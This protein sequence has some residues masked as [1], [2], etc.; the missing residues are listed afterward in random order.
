MN[1]ASQQF[2]ITVE[3]RQIEEAISCIFHTLLLHRSMGKFQYKEEGSFHISTLGT[4]DVDCDFINL[5]YVRLSSEELA[6]MLQREI[7][8]FLDLMRTNDVA[9][10]GEISIEFY[11][12]RRRNWLF[13]EESIPWE[14]WMVHVNVVKP[15]TEHQHCLMRE[16]V[17][18]SLTDIVL[19]I[20]RSI[21]RPMYLPK[22]PVQ[23]ELSLVFDTRFSDVQPYL[24]QIRHK[25]DH[26]SA[27]PSLTTAFQKLLKGT[28]SL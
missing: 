5:T 18:E 20:C 24:Y 11:E 10:V 1:A 3:S 25:L 23:S 28:L 2:E 6:C 22:M 15:V 17:G 13:G 27:A 8:H 26:L 9:S 21:N 19:S 16:M 12:K 14:I 7:V 4:E